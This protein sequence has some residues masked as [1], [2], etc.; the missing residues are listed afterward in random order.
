MAIL[1]N[2]YAEEGEVGLGVRE[3]RNYWG[4]KYRGGET[5][6]GDGRGL[7][8]SARRERLP[9]D[10]SGRPRRMVGGVE[11]FEVLDLERERAREG[12]GEN[13]P[14]GAVFGVKY[15]SVCIDIPQYLS[16]MFRRMKDTGM[17]VI[18]QEVDVSNGLEG[19]VKDAKRTLMENDKSIQEGDIFAVINCTGLG[20]RHFVGVE[21]A[22]KLFPVRGQTI[23]VKGEATKART[24]VGFGEED[25]VVYVIPRPRSGTTILGG[26]KQVGNWSAE[27]D[28]E[29]NQRIVERIKGWGLAEEL[30]M[31]GGAK[32][33]GFEVISYQVGLRPG[34]KGGPRVEVEKDGKVDGCWVVHSYGHG[35]GGYQCSSGCGERVA[36]IV[37]GL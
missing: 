1:E 13:V 4:P 36:E 19:V 34:R 37:G 29:L 24:Y 5:E 31:Q 32:E 11:G 33:K 8:W 10:G 30:R 22:A 2:N 16:F 26:C 12:D 15:Q 9:D 3:S 17:T 28:E 21:E 25:E 6:G 18:R 14:D 7:W 23:L 35:G 20:A 27:V